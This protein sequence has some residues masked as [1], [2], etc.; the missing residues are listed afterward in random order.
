MQGSDEGFLV[1]F[2][3]FKFALSLKLRDLISRFNSSSVR[4]C[5]RL[6]FNGCKFMMWIIKVFQK[7]VTYRLTDYKYTKIYYNN[8]IFVL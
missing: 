1:N 6:R 5:P 7:I 3:A 8:T 2:P 4:L